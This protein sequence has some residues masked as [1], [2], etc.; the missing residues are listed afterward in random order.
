MA[1]TTSELILRLC[2]EMMA[3]AARLESLDPLPTLTMSDITDQIVAGIGLLDT[4]SDATTSLRP[5][6]E[7]SA[8]NK[9]EEE[10]H[11]ESST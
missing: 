4:S 9:Q 7:D 1:E 11:Y 6:G 8:A 5:A 10:S 3:A 2:D